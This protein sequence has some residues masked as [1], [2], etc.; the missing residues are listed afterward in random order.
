MEEVVMS[1]ENPA[2]LF[3]DLLMQ[4][5]ESTIPPKTPFFFPPKVPKFHGLMIIARKQ[6]KKGR[7]HKERCVFQTQH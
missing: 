3:T 2:A 7:K 5:A 1:A 6:L 4:T